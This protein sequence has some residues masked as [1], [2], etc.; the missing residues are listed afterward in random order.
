MR[1]IDRVAAAL[2]AVATGIVVVSNA[3]D[4]ETW[5]L[6]VTVVRDRRA[7]RGSLV[8]LHTALT[9]TDDAA[10]VVAWDMPFVTSELTRLVAGRARDV[11]FATIPESPFGADGLEPMCAVYTRAALPFV[12]A[13]LDEHDFR[14]ARFIDRLPAVTRVGVD[15][16]RTVG[17]PAR[18]FF[19]VNTADDLTVAEQ[20][21]MHA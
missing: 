8:G 17:D 14:L 13:A 6:G 5:L 18:L 4:A 20:M 10:F 3:P 15:A 16:I 19:N 11:P 7:E 9:E 2:R 1:I 12:K 21:A